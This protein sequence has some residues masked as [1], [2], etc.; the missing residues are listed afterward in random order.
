MNGY[1]SLPMMLG[2]AAAASV[3]LIVWCKACQHHVE[4]DPAEIAAQYG[5][6]THK[7]FLKC[8]V[9]HNR[10]ADTSP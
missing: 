10:R 2:A 5:A 8:E 1:P 9:S 7:I 6:A 4:P 3:R